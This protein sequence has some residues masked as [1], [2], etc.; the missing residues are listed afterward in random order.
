M[1]WRRKWQPTPVCLPGKPPGERSLAGYSPW[2]LEELDT[3]E[4]L[5]HHHILR[6]PRDKFLKV[7]LPQDGCLALVLKATWQGAQCV[8]CCC[9]F[10]QEG[11]SIPV[12]PSG[13]KAEV[14]TPVLYTRFPLFPHLFP[15]SIEQFVSV[16]H[17][18]Q[19]H[20]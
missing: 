20:S 5:H 6:S 2:S 12:T 7:L 9:C 10:R 3:T 15:H 14:L 8:H 1:L 16:T 19:C 4:Q 13:L 11:K 18:E 17:Y